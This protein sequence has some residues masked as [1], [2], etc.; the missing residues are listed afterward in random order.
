MEYRGDEHGITLV[1][2][3]LSDADFKVR[4]EASEAIV[5]ISGDKAINS[6]INYMLVFSNAPDQDAA[7][8]ALMT[9]LGSDN[10]R[11]L[12]PVLRDGSVAARKTAI[13][14]LAW[15][16]DNKYFSTV[17]PFTSSQDEQVKA[18]AMKSLASLAGPAD[19]TELI[20]L[21]S[22]T[23]KPEYISDIQDALAAAAAKI[24]DPEKRS[25]L[26]IKSLSDNQN[27]D[28]SKLNDFKIK[29]IPVLAKTGGREA[30]A[31]VLKEF[32][33]GNSAVRDVCFKTLTG[34]RDYSA[35]SALYEIC[36]SGNKTFEGP[37]FDGYVRQIRSTD[38]TDEQK[39]LLFRKIMP[40]ALTAARKNV[41]T[42]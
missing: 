8:S 4:K 42:Y 12:I 1:T 9:V 24:S 20:K 31:V 19:Q 33:N 10:M 11:F 15:N 32:E 29:I 40:Y 2:S 18:A 23:D 26:L 41:I 28:A 21:L 7:K 39:L 35:S 34:W 6:L 3:S 30:L 27:Q 17:L 22:A 37:A 5:K 14:L 16:K 38:L 25:E 13:E 36:A